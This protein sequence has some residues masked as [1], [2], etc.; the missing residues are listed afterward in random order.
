MAGPALPQAAA[1]PS[2]H[3]AAKRGGEDLAR[4]KDFAT[5]V[6]AQALP[7]IHEGRYE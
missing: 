7:F 1:K 5:P 2:K 6:P 4:D 3:A